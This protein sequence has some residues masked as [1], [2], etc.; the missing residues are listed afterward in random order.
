[1]KK[2]ITVKE[3]P[4][5]EDFHEYLDDT[6]T[7]LYEKSIEKVR[8]IYT[9]IRLKELEK[10]CNRP[11]LLREIDSK[12]IGQT[13]T[14]FPILLDYDFSIIDGMHRLADIVSTGIDY[15]KEIGVYFRNP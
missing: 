14:D 7:L 13:K 11:L 8:F 10:A 9:I 4:N 6:G 15:E 12:M 3:L 1:M 2:I 5:P